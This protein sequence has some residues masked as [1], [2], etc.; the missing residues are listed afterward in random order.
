VAGERRLGRTQVLLVRM[1]SDL[2]MGELK[3]T[4]AGNLFTVFGEPDLHVRTFPDG[5]LPGNPARR[6]CLRPHD[7]RHL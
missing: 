5:H 2:L 4:K 3:N 7:G 1:N 6:R